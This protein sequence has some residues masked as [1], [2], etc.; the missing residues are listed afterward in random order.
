MTNSVSPSMERD[1]V[2]MESTW[3]DSSGQS[4]DVALRESPELTISL[5]PVFPPVRVS[6]LLLDSQGSW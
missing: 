4:A 3:A 1:V 5:R 6:S 2:W